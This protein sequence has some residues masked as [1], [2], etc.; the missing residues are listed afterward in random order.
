MPKGIFDNCPTL[1]LSPSKS[2]TFFLFYLCVDLTTVGQFWVLFPSSVL[3][4]RAGAFGL[5]LV[6]TLPQDLDTLDAHKLGLVKALGL[7][8]VAQGSKTLF[9][10]SRSR[11]R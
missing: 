6:K 3:V 8:D 5:K 1:I 7:V 10:R 11:S 4:L 9:T 2:I